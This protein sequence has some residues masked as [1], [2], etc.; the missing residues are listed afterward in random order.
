M[1]GLV[2]TEYLIRSDRWSLKGIHRC[3]PQGEQSKMYKSNSN[4]N[5]PIYNSPLQTTNLLYTSSKSYLGLNWHLFP[6][7]N[8]AYSR[9]PYSTLH[10]SSYQPAHLNRFKLDLA[11]WNRDKSPFQIFTFSHNHH[12]WLWHLLGFVY[13]PLSP[14]QTKTGWRRW[15]L[16]SVSWSFLIKL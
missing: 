3:P 15:R 8:T 2:Y 10:Y 5:N 16:F 6:I 9:T 14:N 13:K 11:V 12:H 4:I 1:E 7:K